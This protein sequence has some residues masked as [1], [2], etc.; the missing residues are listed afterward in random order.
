[1]C[2]YYKLSCLQKLPRQIKE[3]TNLNNSLMEKKKVIFGL[4]RN[5]AQ[6]KSEYLQQVRKSPGIP[7]DANKKP[8]ASVL[9][10]SPIPSPLNPFYKNTL[11]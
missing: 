5:M 10:M 4:S 7:F 9:K 2:Y 1:M 3:Q 6:R 11:N 8:L